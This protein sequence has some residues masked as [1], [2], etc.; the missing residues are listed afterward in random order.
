ME[1]EYAG[2]VITSPALGCVCNISKKYCGH[3]Y[4]CR[5]IG[6]IKNTE[7]YKTCP[8]RVKQNTEI[9]QKT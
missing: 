3:I 5:E 1:C 7:G 2:K 8:L 9:Q 4:Y 6:N